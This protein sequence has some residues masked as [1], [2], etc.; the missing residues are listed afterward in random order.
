MN[1]P[2][3]HP[4]AAVLNFLR[5][6]PVL[7]TALVLGY[8][9][10]IL[11]MHNPLVH[12]SIW[13]EAHLSL[14]LYNKVTI[15]IY[16]ITLFTLAFTLRSR[17]RLHPQNLPRKVFYLFSI[18]LLIALHARFMF[19]K[20]IEII[21]SLEF[22][23]LAFLLFPLAGTFGGA[24]FFCLPF[25][26]IDEWYQYIYLYPDW[27]DYMDLNDIVMDLHGAAL[28][29]LGLMIAGITAFQTTQ[30]LW[31]RREFVGLILLLLLVIGAL[32][33]C[34]LAPYADTACS[35]TVFLFNEHPGPEPFFR[36][37]AGSGTS[38]HVMKPYE[39]I[40]AIT[41]VVLFYFGLDGY[42]FK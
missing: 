6:H 13:V 15:I 24:V 37:S 19:E 17:L 28:M 16:L 38:F 20:N 4:L 8:F 21:H 30:P 1:N 10:F 23:I 33:T 25:M 14:A 40:V 41:A 5:Q 2:P 29:M 12:L 22:T 32:S 26:L 31:K 7:N 9:V 34:Y 42:F 36:I 39:G 18:T 35:N 27:N 3:A 11:L